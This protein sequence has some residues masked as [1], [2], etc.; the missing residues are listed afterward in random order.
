MVDS[1]KILEQLN[2]FYSFSFSQLVAF[3]VGLLA[4]VGVLIPIVASFY[5]NKRTAIEI[6]QLHETFTK[7]I[8]ALK[9]EAKKEVREELKKDLLEAEALLDKKL[10]SANGSIYHV[11]ASHLISKKLYKRAANSLGDAMGE[12][13]K[14]NDQLNLGRCMRI[15]IDKCLPNISINEEPNLETFV[16]WVE[17]LAEKIRVINDN[18]QLTDKITALVKTAKKAKQRLLAEQKQNNST[19]F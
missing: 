19:A 17:A 7:E 12:Y 1:L 10:A 8:A 15:F 5:Q 6:K 4:F 2:S 11:Q 14:A 18:G 3:T 9:E 13:V 16:S